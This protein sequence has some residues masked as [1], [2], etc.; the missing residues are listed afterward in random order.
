MISNFSGYVCQNPSTSW[1]SILGYTLIVE[2]SK[3]EMFTLSKV[4]D[5]IWRKASTWIHTDQLIRALQNEYNIDEKTARDDTITFIQQLISIS[6]IMT[7]SSLEKSDSSETHDLK[8]SLHLMQEKIPVQIKNL[9]EVEHIP[10]VSYLELTR[11][12]NLRCAH[13]YNGGSSR[14]ELNIDQIK[15]IL[16]DLVDLG[17][18]DL[19]LTGGEPCIHKNFEDIL[20]YA[21]D[22]R[23]CITLKTNGTMIDERLASL[24]K[25]TLVSE[26]HVSLY[27]LKSEEHESITM[28]KG[29]LAKT[30]HGID[31][32]LREGIK[33]RLSVPV[34]KL[35]YLSVREI[36]EFA[37]R[38]NAGC[39]FDPIIIA[40]IDGSRY[41]IGLRIGEYEWQKLLDDGLLSE[42]I[43]PNLVNLNDSSSIQSGTK[44]PMTGNELVCGAGSSSITITASGDVLPCICLPIRMGNVLE[45]RLNNIWRHEKD[46][47]PVRTL[48]SKLFTDCIHC[49]H[50]EYCPRCPA[51]IFLETGKLAGAAPVIC[52]TAAFIAH[53][54]E[55]RNIKKEV[56]KYDK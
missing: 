46:W 7:S 35:N 41:P 15:I 19:I 12:C 39:G 25:K 30:L 36:S 13:C 56:R 45:D 20:W 17:C 52:T 47:S 42:V 2:H 16:D 34:T 53:S 48:T 54:K 44:K 5:F 40:Q 24:F 10:I 32:L 26:I 51:V 14:H 50:I 31:C 8:D 33:I 23:F 22:R 28:T 11:N 4:A 3:G 1:R 43:Y 21:R 55:L 29:S 49:N 9:C 18:L 37:R 38:I 6:L 27:S